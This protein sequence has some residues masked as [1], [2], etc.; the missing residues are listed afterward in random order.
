MFSLL[1]MFPFVF[2]QT[3]SGQELHW[4]HSNSEYT[5]W[6]P[7]IIEFQAFKN[8]THDSLNVMDVQVNPT[9][10]NIKERHKYV[11]PTDLFFFLQ[12]LH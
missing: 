6:F 5:E 4:N 7:S 3:Y 11:R 8:W 1:T 12:V 10:V 9:N 2:S